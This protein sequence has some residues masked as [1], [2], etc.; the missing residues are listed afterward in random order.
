MSSFL[1]ARLPTRKQLNIAETPRVDLVFLDDAHHA[2]RR[3]RRA[4]WLT[5]EKTLETVYCVVR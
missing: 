3:R 4:Y 5:R 1:A 2:G